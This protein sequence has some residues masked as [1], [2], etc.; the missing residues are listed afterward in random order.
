MT[1]QRELHNFK[2]DAPLYV[3]RKITFPVT[4]QVLQTMTEIVLQILHNVQTWRVSVPKVTDV[5]W[6]VATDSN[7]AQAAGH[8]YSCKD[9]VTSTYSHTQS[10]WL[11]HKTSAPKNADS[12]KNSMVDEATGLLST[13]K[14]FVKVE[15]PQ[16]NTTVCAI[17]DNEGLVKL[18]NKRKKSRNGYVTEVLHQIYELIDR[19]GWKVE[20]MWQRRTSVFMKAADQKGRLPLVYPTARLFA[21]LMKTH[22]GPFYVPKV[23]DKVPV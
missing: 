7:P 18:L 6:V 1:V 17:Q 13:F 20:F 8:I 21:C 14:H 2:P 11:Q 23:T 5:E 3:R 22:G 12:Y 10:L 16:P 15:A 4:R 9:L 19:Q